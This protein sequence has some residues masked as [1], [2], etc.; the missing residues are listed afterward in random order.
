MATRSQKSE[1]AQQEVIG[2]ISERLVFPVSI[3]MVSLGERDVN[4]ADPFCAK[5]PE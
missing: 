2:N 1:N 4:V 3:E 5:S